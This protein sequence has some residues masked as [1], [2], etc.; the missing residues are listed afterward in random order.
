MGSA[1]EADLER[2][3]RSEVQEQWAENVATAEDEEPPPAAAAAMEAGAASDAF[4]DGVL[5]PSKSGPSPSASA[6]EQPSAAALL[7]AQE[8][9][10]PLDALDEDLEISPPDA[11]TES[12]NGKENLGH[13][14]RCQSELQH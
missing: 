7:P 2:Q 11:G 8:P 10:S 1:D 13:V 5:P 3:E 6:P 14:S 9:K 4:P 12:S